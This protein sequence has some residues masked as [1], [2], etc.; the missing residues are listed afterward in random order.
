M[1]TEPTNSPRPD[2]FKARMAQAQAAGRP[3][4]AHQSLGRELSA[5][6]DQFAGALMAIYGEGISAQK[7]VATALVARGIVRPS[8]QTVDWTGENLAA[9]LQALNTDLDDAY[10]ENGFGA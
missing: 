9:E 2:A 10:R 5:S 7:D 1:S 8:S 3:E 6:E 4:L